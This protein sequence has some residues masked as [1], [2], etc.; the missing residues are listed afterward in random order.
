M[1]GLD[2]FGGEEGGEQESWEVW[3]NINLQHVNQAV[4]TEP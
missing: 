3:V 1:K 2:W 4:A